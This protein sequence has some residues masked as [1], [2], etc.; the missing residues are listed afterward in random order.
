MAYFCWHELPTVCVRQLGS[1]GLTSLRRAWCE[2]TWYSTVEGSAKLMSEIPDKTPAS[3]IMSL[4]EGLRDGRERFQRLY[5]SMIRKIALKNQLAPQEADDVVSVTYLNVI[6]GI[7]TYDGVRPF[8]G[9]LNGVVEKVIL[10]HRRMARKFQGGLDSGFLQNI[11]QRE[12]DQSVLLPSDSDWIREIVER[13]LQYW[14][15]RTADT[16]KE[17]VRL[18]FVEKLTYLEIAKKQGRESEAVRSAVCRFLRELK[19]SVEQE[20]ISATGSA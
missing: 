6:T 9:W 13:A 8:R 18:Y 16:N 10:Q 15:P 17:A 20:K 7:G 1:S 12:S 2:R 14:Y 3:L 19:A 11:P 4:R 5:L